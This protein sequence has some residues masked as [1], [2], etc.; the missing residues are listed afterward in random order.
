[1]DSP[2]TS[3]KFKINPPETWL[4]LYGDY[5]YRYAMSRLRNPE[6]AS[7]CLQDTLLA[8]IKNLKSFD[9]RI[10]VKFWLRGI[11]RNKIIDQFRKAKRESRADLGEDEAVLESAI[12]KYSGI[13]S[14]FPEEWKFDPRKNFDRGE[15]WE[16][17]NTCLDELKDPVRQA[18]ILRMLE[19]METEEVC[20]V[21]EI[22]PNYLWVLLHRARKQLKILMNERWRNAK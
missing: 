7:D 6:Q 4:E 5:L 19:D 1:M 22:D 20:K 21:M 2:D 11:M 3:K 18:F 10:D 12:F 8:G 15:F 9:G 14:L 17:F 13:G 16:V